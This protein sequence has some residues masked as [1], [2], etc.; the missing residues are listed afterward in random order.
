M[1]IW[2]QEK[3]WAAGKC[4][5]KIAGALLC[6]V[7]IGCG[8]KDRAVSVPVGEPL[9]GA[10]DGV[11]ESE[12]G[13]EPAGTA[14]QSESGTQQEGSVIYVHV[15]GAVNA[16]GVVLLPEGSRGQA[17]LEAAGGFSQD[18]AEDAVNLAQPLT[19]GMQLYFPTREE[20]DALRE[21]GAEAESGLVNINT[22]GVELLC[23]LPGIGEARAKAI[24]AYREESGGFQT[25]EDIMQ[26]SGIKDSAYEKIKDLI[27]VK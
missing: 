23:T 26:V 25:P 8:D 20:A 10:F 14:P 3:Q 7:F 18:A 19:D 17:A 16:P 4:L 12:A 1:N 21:S 2:M 11:A 13:G 5:M 22:A 6:I 27:I 24:V 15:C 9:P